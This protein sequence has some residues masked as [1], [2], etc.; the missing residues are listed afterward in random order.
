MIKTNVQI[1]KQ[2][3]T[4]AKVDI[5][6][7]GSVELLFFLNISA[8]RDAIHFRYGCRPQHLSELCPFDASFTVD[9][10]L[11]VIK[12]DS[13]HYNAMKFKTSLDN[14]WMTSAMMS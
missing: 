13:Y 9:H 11:I 14:Y 3:L 4:K 8:F 7:K 2:H 10:A 6:L 12:V 1:L 5:L